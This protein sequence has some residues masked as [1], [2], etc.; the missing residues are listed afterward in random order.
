MRSPAAGL[1]LRLLG[2]LVFRI[3][4]VGFKARPVKSQSRARARLNLR[5]EHNWLPGRV[6]QD[7][8]KEVPEKAQA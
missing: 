3:L 1:G 2:V 5:A 7:S 8:D 4:G 6:R